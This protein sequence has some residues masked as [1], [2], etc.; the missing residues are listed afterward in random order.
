MPGGLR[1][2]IDR[3]PSCRRDTLE[4][5][6]WVRHTV[7]SAVWGLLSTASFEEAVVQVVNLGRDADTAGAVVGAWAGAAYG[8]ASIPAHWQEALH[9][10]W[11]LG[12]GI[13]WTAASLADLAS[14]LATLEGGIDR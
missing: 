3:A 9:G 10:E 4:N 14:R 7:E 13:R 8:Q 1:S 5:T 12:S 2:V 11:P 6:G